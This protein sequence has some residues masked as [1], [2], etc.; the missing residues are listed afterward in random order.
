MHFV[1]NQLNLIDICNI[2]KERSWQN[3]N[4][5]YMISTIAARR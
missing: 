2:Q 1:I 3:S 4:W 5:T